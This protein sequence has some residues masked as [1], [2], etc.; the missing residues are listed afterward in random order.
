MVLAATLAGCAKLGPQ[1]ENV[2]PVAT[3]WAN[4]GAVPR[5]PIVD[6]AQWWKAFD[7]PVLDALVAQTLEQNLTL[8]QASSRLQAARALVRTAEAQR[9]PQVGATTE[10]RRQKRLPGPAESDFERASEDN[11]QSPTGSRTSSYFQAGFDASWELDLFGHFAATEQTSRATAGSALAESRMA[12]VSVVA[13]MARSYIELRAAQRRLALQRENLKDQNRL[14]ALT[15]DRRAAGIVG[16]LDLDRSLTAASETAA[17]LPLLEQSIQQSAQRIAVLT[18]KATLDSDLL[19]PMPQPVAE[20]LA[21]RVLPADLVRVRPQ[22]QRAERLIAQA[23]AEL[24]IAVADLYPRMTLVGDIKASGSLLGTPLA[25]RATNA[26]AGLSIHI[27][28]LD[29]GARRA[30][31]SAREAGLTEAIFAYRLAV[32]E[33]IE[34]T[35]NALTAIDT[36]RRKAME[37]EIRLAAAQRTASHADTLYQRGITDMLNRL[38][39]AKALREAQLSS[40]DVVEQR[41]L[42]VVVLYKAVGGASLEPAL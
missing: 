26:S 41:A 42:A 36:G 28:L 31:V 1:P 17:Q 20:R 14:V 32:L 13:E 7:E 37:E 12:R 3:D 35:E 16:D 21:L 6:P 38:D 4:R 33:G 22:I 34:D 19:K 30:T 9:L 2:Q 5:T 18:G 11:L 8:L 10:G 25:E 39:T 24:G 29:W 23:N 27:P 15:R 40:A